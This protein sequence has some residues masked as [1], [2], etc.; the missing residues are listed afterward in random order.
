MPTQATDWKKAQCKPMELTKATA[1]KSFGR[2]EN[3]LYNKA[4]RG[5]VNPLC[6]PAPTS[7]GFAWSKRQGSSHYRGVGATV[8]RVGECAANRKPSSARRPRVAAGLIDAGEG[9]KR[10]SNGS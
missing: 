2:R 1:I 8:I 4:A 9:P 3:T 6:W 10:I 5:G 7:G